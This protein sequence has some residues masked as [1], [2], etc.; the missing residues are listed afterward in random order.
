V[1]LWL[2]IVPVALAGLLLTPV[3]VLLMLLRLPGQGW[4]P[5]LFHRIAVTV[6]GVRV[7]AT[8]E[9][10]ARRPLLI[11]ANHVSW[12]DIV[13][14]G[15]MMPLSFVAKAEVAGWPLFGQ[16]ARLQRTIFV[17]RARR[18][19]TREVSRSLADRLR[20]GD[21]M[22][23]FAEGTTGDGTRVLPFRSA[24]LGAARD[25][26][27]AGRD[28]LLQPLSIVYT[29]RDGLPLN[30]SGRRDIAWVGDVDLLPHLASVLRGGPIE[31]T[32]SFGAPMMFGPE[33]D[34]KAATRAMEAEVRR[35][36]TLSITGREAG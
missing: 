31:A 35:L 14:L 1:K 6:M 36:T 20:E 26:G 27:A 13:V 23:L 8:G 29:R 33:S 11:V 34:R 19:A 24:L 22:V 16:M 30:A 25:A 4:P 18:T 3:Q 17:D 21:A 5:L 32:V 10:P 9:V 12:L 2:K 15:S 7:K 28:V